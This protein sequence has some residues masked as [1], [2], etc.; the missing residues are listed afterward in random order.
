MSRFSSIFHQTVQFMAQKGLA[1]VARGLQEGQPC[2]LTFHGL[3]EDSDPG[4]I[5]AEL[6]TPVSVFRDICRHLSSRYRVCSLSALVDAL[7]RR[8]P[9]PDGTVALT[10]DDGY[11]SNYS[12]AYPILQEF[13]LPATL[14]VT[15]G[16]VDRTQSLWFHRMEY[17][18]AHSP[19]RAEYAKAAAYLKALP[20]ENLEEETAGLES[21]LGARLRECDP[22]PAIFEPLTWNQIREMQASGL[23]EMGGH[24]QTH[25]ILGRCG[26]ET[27]RREIQQSFE[28]LAVETGVKPRLFAYPNGQ[29]GDYTAGTAEL[30]AE[31]GFTSA[32][33]MSPGF[34]QPGT[35]RFEIPRY[36]APMSVAETEATVSGAF[37]TLKAW[38]L[39]TREA[40][41]A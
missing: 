16:F 10:F 15:S 6:H 41:A 13:N 39:A 31:T 8:L 18:Y 7:Q 1:R 32:V 9:L 2:I 40:L 11:A 17:A 37:E 29:P 3:R 20:Q 38:R 22:A 12:L 19:L 30:L 5:D 27:A 14:F 25:L 24:T 33:T 23:V 35:S 4:L 26:R 34:V 28:R 36:G 21:K